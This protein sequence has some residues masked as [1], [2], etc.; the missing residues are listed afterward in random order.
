MTPEQQA[1]VQTEQAKS[2]TAKADAAKEAE[3]TKQSGIS[4]EIEK[5]KVKQAQLEFS[6]IQEQAMLGKPDYAVVAKMVADAM[7]E[8]KI[9]EFQAGSGARGQ[10]S[11]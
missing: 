8:I 2:E 7:A 10:N 5:E 4:L 3:R 1:D 9:T 6:K 11:Q